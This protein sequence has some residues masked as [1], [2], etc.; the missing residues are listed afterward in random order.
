MIIRSTEYALSWE[1][2]RRGMYWFAPACVLLVVGC[3]APFY[4]VLSTRADVYLELNHAVFAVVCWVPLVMALASRAFLRRQYTLPVRS[5]TL[6]ACALANGALAVAIIYWVIALSFNT[7]FHTGWP[8]W[9]PAWWAVVVYAAFQAAVWSVVGGRGA[10]LVPLG[11]GSLLTLFAGQPNLYRRLVPTTSANGEVVWPVI[12]AAELAVSLVAVGVCYLAAVYVVSRD[13]RGDGWSLAWLSPGWWAACFQDR[14]FAAAPVATTGRFTPRHFRS[15][16]AAQF[17]MEWRS[18]G[19]FVPIAVG[20][21]FVFLWLIAA[22][23]RL[24]QFSL[25]GALAGLTGLVLLTSPLIGLYLGHRSERF[26]IK[27]FLATRPLADREMAMVVLRHAAVVCAAGAMVWLVGYAVTESI[28]GHARTGPLPR[29]QEPTWVLWLKVVILAG[30]LLL[31]WTLVGLGAA[32]A[33]ARSWLV[34]VVALGVLGG[35]TLLVYTAEK[36]A[37]GAQFVKFMLATVC[38]GGTIWAFVAAWRRG[39]V[40]VPI[41][42]GSLAGYLVILTCFSTVQDR[43]VMALDLLLPIGFFAAPLAPLAAAPLALAWNRHR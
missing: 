24:D 23:N 13:R 29:W 6:V 36:F 8:F 3:V 4:A 7:M 34:P 19:R 16:E 35:L 27:P 26:D 11:L 38:L 33:M 39:L 18:K 21:L 31:L 42:V 20:S 41:V 40:S 10:L 9:G 37:L 12:T 2:W 14:R 5:G 30:F 22:L 1:Y 32:L 43:P 25:A 28:W 15:P 17:W